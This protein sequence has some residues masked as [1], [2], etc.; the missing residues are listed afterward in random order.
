MCRYI[1]IG[2]T[3]MFMEKYNCPMI[4]TNSDKFIRF[5]SDY[6]QKAP[7]N[8]FVCIPSEELSLS[9]ELRILLGNQT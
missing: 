7:P 8:M 1:I 6:S 4:L 9:N 5:Y 3:G 2:D